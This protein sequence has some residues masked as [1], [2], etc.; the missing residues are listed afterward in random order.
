MKEF[1]FAHPDEIGSSEYRAIY[2]CLND[3]L[4]DCEADARQALAEA[5][6]E[7]FM[8]HT[9]AMLQQ[10]REPNSPTED[11][12]SSSSG[13]A[14]DDVPADAARQIVSAIQEYMF[15]KDGHWQWRDL[16]G[17]DFIEF[18]TLLLSQHDLTPSDCE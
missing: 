6:L 3:E 10:V 11:A 15:L 4:E 1:H 5:I 8:E 2:D 16:S 18:V 7:T 14:L 17:A 13:R 12:S 9:S